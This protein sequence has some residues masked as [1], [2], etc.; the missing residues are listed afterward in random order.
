MVSVLPVLPPVLCLAAAFASLLVGDRPRLLALVA[1]SAQAVL[2]GVFVALLLGDLPVVHRLGGW[3][4]PVGIVFVADRLAVFFL[5]LGL[6]VFAAATIYLFLDHESESRSRVLA[7]VFLLEMGILG[8]FLTGDLFDFYVFFE[9][10]GLSSYG[11][12]GYRRSEEHVESALKF[13]ALSLMGSTLM[14]M[15]IG[16][17]YAQTGQLSFAALFAGSTAVHSQPLFLFAVS[18]VLVALCLKCALVPLHFWL[19]DAHSIA[20]TAISVLLSGAVVKLGIYGIVRLLGSQHEWVWAAARPVLLGAGAHTAILAALVA[21]G[22]RDLKRLLAW[23]TASQMG[24]VVTAAALGT[25]AGVTA[26]IV[27]AL[28]H[29][30]MKSSLFLGAGA[31]MTATGQRQWQRMGGLLRHSPLLATA[32]FVALLSLAGIPPLAGFTG[33]LA[34]FGALI[35]EREWGALLALLAASSL[36]LYLAVRVWLALFG[37]EATG[38]PSPVPA[39][40]RITAAL[41]ALT[42]LVG[43]ASGPLIEAAQLAA[44]D[45]LDG[46]S[47]RAAV[48]GHGRPAR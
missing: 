13:A 39:K 36:M 23:S 29:A 45:L 40:T 32:F 38:A 14:L 41:A 1:A 37:G 17:I 4:A 15:G 35:E 42:L 24:Y 30:L 2:L 25:R 9:L 10:M 5:G 8:G 46:G 22:Q 7:L 33:K 18:L 31:V 12:V 48:L 28:A 34:I 21:T 6:A 44:H 19:P 26:A 43:L 3:Q 27:H 47:Y 20:P 11:L 16:A